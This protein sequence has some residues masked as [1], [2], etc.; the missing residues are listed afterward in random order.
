MSDRIKKQHTAET[1]KEMDRA[2]DRMAQK[3][4]E[5]DRAEG[6]FGERAMSMEDLDHI[7]GGIIIPTNEGNDYSSI[8][9]KDR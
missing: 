5:M 8:K 7:A 6:V 4:E 3:L 1:P 2:V 9:R